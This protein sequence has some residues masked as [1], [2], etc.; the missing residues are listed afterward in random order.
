[1]V[2]SAWSRAGPCW[3][4]A[5]VRPD[6][7]RPSGDGRRRRYG[8]SEGR[9]DSP[10]TG[11]NRGS[12]PRSS[13]VNVLNVIIAVFA[14]WAIL[15]L[16]MAMLRGLARP[17]PEPP[18]AGETEFTYRAGQLP[19][20]LSAPH[21]AAHTRNGQVKGSDV[22]TASFARLVAERTG[23]HVLY[24]HHKSNTDP[25]YD[26]KAPYKAYLKQL[27]QTTDIRFVMDI[28]GAGPRRNFGVA[29]GTI[30]GRT[31][32]TRQREL[33]VET[34]AAHGFHPDN[35]RLHRLDRL[36][37]DE[38]FPGGEKQHTITQ[39]VWQ[40]LH[41][42]AAQFELNAHLRTFKPDQDGHK[43][44]NGDRQRLHRAINAFVNLV[45]VLAD[46]KRSPH[47]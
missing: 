30:H 23:A 33:I 31:C 34:L 13:T 20:L 11:S 35:P 4:S 21:G 47:K 16:G 29:L 38:T 41:I 25:N 44:F 26:R 10:P 9:P 32:S 1:M 12:C 3:R 18:P 19:I 46:S 17:I 14:A 36:D 27:I 45:R 24:A 40:T 42:P 8:D 39:Y 7:R 6:L 2:P 37:L 43:P 22:Y 5:P 15:A 28:H